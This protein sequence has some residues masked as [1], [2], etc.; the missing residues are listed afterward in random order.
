VKG[1]TAKTER[2][3]LHTS[4]FTHSCGV[5]SLTEGGLLGFSAGVGL[6]LLS[7][8]F[9]KVLNRVLLISDAVFSTCEHV[10]TRARAPP[11]L[12]ALR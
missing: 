8:N 11:G 12:R 3:V 2:R 10:C 7:S 4:V 5:M 1:E 6:R 9:H